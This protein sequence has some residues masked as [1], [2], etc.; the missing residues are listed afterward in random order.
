MIQPSL[1]P[2]INEELH[3]SHPGIVRMKGLARLYVWWPGIDRQIEQVVS[4]CA[5]C[6]LNRQAPRVALLHPWAW[7]TR[8]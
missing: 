2:D 6:Q 4:D 5:G 7:P 1:Q 8:P 3:T